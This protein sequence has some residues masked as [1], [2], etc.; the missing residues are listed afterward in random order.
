MTPTDDI[1]KNEADEH[2]GYIVNNR[3]WRQGGS[4]GKD[5]WEVDVL[6]KIDPELF[7]QNPLK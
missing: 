1:V 6:E 7:M 4:G 2:T 5:E 3:R